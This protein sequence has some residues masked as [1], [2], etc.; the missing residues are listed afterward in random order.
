MKKHYLGIDVLRGLGIFSVITLHTAFYYFDGIFDLD[1]SDPPLIIT[2]IGFLLMFAGLFAMLSGFVHTLQAYR[3]IKEKNYTLQD[4]LRYSVVAG[5]YILL[6]AYLYFLIT[7]PGIVLFD[8]R[9]FDNSFLVELIKNG[10]FVFPSVER[11]LYIDSLVMIGSNII[12][13]GLLTFAGFKFIKSDKNRSVYF[14]V[15]GVVILLVSI[16]RIPLYSVYLDARDDGNYIVVFLLNWFVN[17]NNPV[18]PFLA[19][20]LFGG[21]LST[22]I[23]IG[24]VKKTRILTIISG[25][26]FVVVG[27]FIYITAE[28]TMLER[29]IDYTWY[30]I[31]VFQIG[32]FKLLIIGFLKLYDFRKEDKEMNVI[33]KFL[34]RF[35]IAGLTVFFIEQLFSSSIKEIMLLINKD[36][37]LT[38]PISIIIGLILSVIWGLLLIVWSNYNY[39]YGVEYFY[40]KTMKKFGG[41]EKESKLEE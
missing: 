26:L 8:S 13:L 7:G 17:K 2:L 38:I 10:R 33:S 24:N 36:L 14:Y 1:L 40:V 6:I 12:L 25:V 32:L 19:F 22:L 18:L 29:Q 39:K 28:E 11:I 4:T 37:F 30:G 9:S 20:A 5:L 15:S 27:L 3:K 23:M 21:W 31:M 34:Y 35:G 16:F 41:S